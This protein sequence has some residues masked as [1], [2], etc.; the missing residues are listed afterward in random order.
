MDM[1]NLITL[2]ICSAYNLPFPF[3]LSPIKIPIQ[4]PKNIFGFFITIRRSRPL[5]KY[6]VDIHGC[7][8]FWQKA[9]M[10]YNEIVTKIPEIAESS[11][12][13]DS[14][15]KYYPVSLLE[16]PNS[17]IEISF[18][19]LPLIPI[20]S[21]TSSSFNNDKYGLIVESSENGKEKARATYLPKVFHKKSW[22]F[23]STSLLEKA[24]IKS[25]NFFKYSTFPIENTFAVLFHNNYIQFFIQQFIA[26][27]ENNYGEF[28]PYSVVNDKIIVDKSQNVRNCATFY[29]VLQFPISKNLSG[30]IKKNLEYYL[31]NWKNKN[32]EQAN[33]F[34]LL[35]IPLIMEKVDISEICESLYENLSTMDPQFQLGETLIA[36]H[37]ICPNRKIISYWQKWMY[38]RL[39]NMDDSIDNIFEYNWQSKFLYSIHISIHNS[40]SNFQIKKHVSLLSK[41]INR[42]SVSSQTQMETNYLAVYLEASSNIYGI[43]NIFYAQIMSVWVHLIQRWKNGLF[44]FL[45]GRSARIDITGHVINALQIIIDN[46][47]SGDFI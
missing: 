4:F 34:L 20:S 11:F 42:I 46:P 36:L 12:W 28:V 1:D 24:N 30:K 40:N 5:L 14:R 26:F 3:P 18:M 6:P 10:T 8:G 41:K 32:M 33:A 23:I 31:K 9:Q 35:S 25:G 44:Y 43:N 13:K 16:D 47:F 27:M 39:E 38:A 22:E 19:Q 45:D 7:V 17:T 37:K 15:A 2:S 21:G 29:D